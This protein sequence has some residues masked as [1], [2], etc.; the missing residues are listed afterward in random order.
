MSI[1]IKIQDIIHIH[2]SG[3]YLYF[4]KLPQNKHE[5]GAEQCRFLRTKY[6]IESGT[7]PNK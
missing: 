6:N 1:F 2:Y 7:E 3:H 4:K 5:I